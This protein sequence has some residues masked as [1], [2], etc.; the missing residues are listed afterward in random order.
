MNLATTAVSKMASDFAEN[1]LDLFRKAVSNSNSHQPSFLW[2]PFIIRNG[3]CSHQG[4]TPLLPKK[5]LQGDVSE[6]LTPNLQL[7]CDGGEVIEVAWERKAGPGLTP[8]KHWASWVCDVGEQ[9]HCSHWQCGLGPPAAAS[10][11]AC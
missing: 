11:G 4:P 6:H 2:E 5:P 9:V 10:P 7:P 1:E 8:D 3:N